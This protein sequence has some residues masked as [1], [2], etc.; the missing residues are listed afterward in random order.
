M[1]QRSCREIAERRKNFVA[2]KNTDKRRKN[3]G[4]TKFFRRF[5]V[6][7]EYLESALQPSF[8]PPFSLLP[9]ASSGFARLFKGIHTATIPAGCRYLT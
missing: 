8:I 7:G 9:G 3:F 1:L 4:A 2:T 6:A 5:F